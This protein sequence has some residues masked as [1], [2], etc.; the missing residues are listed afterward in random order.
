[1]LNRMVVGPFFIES[2]AALASFAPIQNLNQ[3][4]KIQDD[5]IKGMDLLLSDSL[6][7]LSDS[8]EKN[9]V[10]KI[11]LIELLNLESNVKRHKMIDSISVFTKKEMDEV[12]VLFNTKAA[13]FCKKKNIPVLFSSNANTVVFGVNSK[14]DVTDDLKSFF[15]EVNK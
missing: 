5:S 10:E 2:E 9:N 4:V 11:A 15:G 14:A 7:R 3:M 8:L 1:M 13:S 6:T 12:F